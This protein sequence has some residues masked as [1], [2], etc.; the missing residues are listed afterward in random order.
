MNNFMPIHF[1]TQVKQANSQ[2]NINY[3][4]IQE[5]IETPNGPI[6]IKEIK[7]L[8]KY[9]STQKIPGPNSF[10]SKFYQAFKEQTIPILHTILDFRKRGYTP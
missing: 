4:I 9:F 1:K 8:I 7:S 3:K 6:T 5:E 2:K 10:T